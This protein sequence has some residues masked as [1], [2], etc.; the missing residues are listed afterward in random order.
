MKLVEVILK[1]T[2]RKSVGIIRINEEVLELPS[3]MDKK[4]MI[5]IPV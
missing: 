2:V 3:G 5:R 1:N 4:K